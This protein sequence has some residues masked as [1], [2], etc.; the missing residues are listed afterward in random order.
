MSG[1]LAELQGLYAHDAYE[2]QGK[3]DG[4]F[5]VDPRQGL[6]LTRR[7]DYIGKALKTYRHPLSQQHNPQPSR[8][9]E[10]E[11]EK[12]GYVCTRRPAPV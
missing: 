6:W 3:T 5:P 9:A 4:D 7:Q 2:Q 11:Q 10:E 8:V 12:I 1:C